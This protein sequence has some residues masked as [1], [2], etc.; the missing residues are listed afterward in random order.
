ML[1]VFQAKLH[2]IIIIILGKYRIYFKFTY[3]IK[4]CPIIFYALTLLLYSYWTLRK[5]ISFFTTGSDHLMH[6]YVFGYLKLIESWL[7]QT[8]KSNRKLKQDRGE[9]KMSFCAELVMY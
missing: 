9:K 6:K 4:P 7:D 5:I 8:K 1:D 2:I 3:A